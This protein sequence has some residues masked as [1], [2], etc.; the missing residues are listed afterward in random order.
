[1]LNS[2]QNPSVAGKD[3]TEED[4]NPVSFSFTMREIILLTFVKITASYAVEHQDMVAAYNVGKKLA[5][6]AAWK[7][8]EDQ[9][10]NFDLTVINPD[11]IIGPMIQPV[12]KST[13]VN[14]TNL[15]AVYNFF[16]GT[17]KEIEGLK[18]PYNQFVCDLSQS[19]AYVQVLI[20]F[21][22]EG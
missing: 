20:R 9:K 2:F 4:W 22:L 3:Y 12:P 8:M 19:R 5:E 10:P 6:Q 18:F 15:F 14:E 16:N 1:V 11:I 13:S 17:Y 21:I 7:F